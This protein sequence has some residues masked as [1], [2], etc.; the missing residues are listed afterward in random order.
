MKFQ[1]LA[2]VAIV[3]LLNCLGAPDSAVADSVV[4]APTTSRQL[5][6]ESNLEGFDSVNFD[7]STDVAESDSSNVE[8]EESA[9]IDGEN[10]R[11]P[12]RHRSQSK[13]DL[14]TL[15][16]EEIMQ[17]M[18]DIYLKHSRSLI[19]KQGRH[20]EADPGGEKE[21]RGKAFKKVY[22]KSLKEIQRYFRDGY[23]SKLN[24]KKL[25]LALRMTTKYLMKKR[26]VS[27]TLARKTSEKAY[28]KTNQRI[29]RYIRKRL[30]FV[31]RA[32]L[33]R[34]RPGTTSKQF[35]TAVRVYFVTYMYLNGRKQLRSSKPVYLV[36]RNE[37]LR[38]SVRL[39]IRARQIYEG[40]NMTPE[41][42]NVI[43]AGLK[44]LKETLFSKDKSSDDLVSSQTV[45]SDI[46]KVER[47]L[48]DLG[49][50]S[51]ESKEDDRV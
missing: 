30:T 49:Q 40:G 4:A 44:Q 27:P 7:S 15:P 25:K 16:Q 48:N 19:R 2:L 35:F 13:L 8:T 39:A 5:K 9:A 20:T 22:L 33:P 11:K 31:L 28:S 32:R 24:M 46:Q 3:Q 36:R 34:N 41:E 14:S 17:K 26:S 21:V 45:K 37:L 51:V 6:I 42:Y 47:D 1:I 29:N 10:L 50:N 23:I 38:P 12:G 43:R 18:I